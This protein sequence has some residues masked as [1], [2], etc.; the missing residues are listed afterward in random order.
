MH[1]RMEADDVN[2][3]TGYLDAIG[4]RLDSIEVRSTSNLASAGAYAYL[5]GLSDRDR[6]RASSCDSYP[7]PASPA[8][9]GFARWG[10][11]GAQSALGRSGRL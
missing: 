6:L 7:V 3:I 10:C 4:L 11:Y 5:Y 2:T 8:N 1:A 9:E